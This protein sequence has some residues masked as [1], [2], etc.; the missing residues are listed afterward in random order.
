[1]KL[2]LPR[3]KSGREEFPPISEGLRGENRILRQLPKYIKINDGIALAL[4]LIN[5]L[6]KCESYKKIICSRVLID[7]T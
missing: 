5:V 3:P 4:I 2:P 7:L 1:M 6:Y